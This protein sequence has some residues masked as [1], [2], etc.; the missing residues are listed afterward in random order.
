MTPDQRRED[1][2]VSVCFADVPAGKEHDELGELSRRLAARYRYCE[3]LLIGAANASLDYEPLM[4]EVAN[5]R[6]L[7]VRPGTPLYRRRSAVASEAI[8]DIIALASIDEQPML[9][10]IEMIELAAL[11][12]SIVIGR[13]R[14]TSLMNPALRALGSS[15]GFRVDMRDMQTAA[16]PRALLNKLL[17]HPDPQLAL[18]FPPS[19]AGIPV[20]WLERRGT[21]GR[22]RSLSELGR[23]LSIVQKL[24]VSTAPRVLTLVSLLSL[25]VVSAGFA[26][27]IYAV[28]VWATLKTIQPGWFTTSLVLGLT[29]AFLGVAIFGISIGLQKIIEAVSREGADD[30][31]D[32]RSAGDMFAQAMTELNV[33]VVTDHAVAEAP[34]ERANGPG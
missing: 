7:M 10:I 24:L 27:A 26:F 19:A 17:A 18:R 28:V 11:K 31:V 34:P 5:V 16:Y 12:G 14:N 32:E 13:R 30:I 3:V 2:F 9:D 1:I 8:G 20:I 22:G 6:L 21:G 4:R 29:A 23:R 25:A 15:A 33:E